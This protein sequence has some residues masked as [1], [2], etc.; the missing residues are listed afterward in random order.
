[1]IPDSLM[2]GHVIVGLVVGTLAGFIHF[3]TLHWSV[4]LLTS[5]TAGKALAVQL[6]RLG[7]VAAVFILL[8][9]WGAATLLSAALG[10]LL[11]RH[12]VLR[13]IRSHA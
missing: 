12:V 5:G 9:H 8:A 1:M 13:R 2:A 11:A 3:T 6:C 10:L 7:L 4:R